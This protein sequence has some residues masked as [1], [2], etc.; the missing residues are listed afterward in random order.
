MPF[1]LFQER[2]YLEGRTTSFRLFVKQRILTTQ[3][4]PSSREINPICLFWRLVNCEFVSGSILFP[5]QRFLT[6]VP[7]LYRSRFQLHRRTSFSS[8][9]SSF[10][11][12]EVSSFV[13]PSRTSIPLPLF[14]L[15]IS[16]LKHPDLESFI[17]R[18]CSS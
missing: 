10:R 5:D 6:Y 12:T 17:V 11:H 8:P 15:I 7:L 4:H 13:T 1:V 16:D 2:E 9:V 18:T 3:L 14:R